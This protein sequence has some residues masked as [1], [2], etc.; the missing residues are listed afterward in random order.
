MQNSP[1]F[2]PYVVADIGG[3]NARFAL[4][5]ELGSNGTK[6]ILEN[7]QT[8]PSSEFDSL[9]QALGLFLSTLNGIKVKGACLAVAGP[10]ARDAFNLTNL[11]WEGSLSSMKQKTG[12]EN[13]L[14]LNDFAAYAYSIRYLNDE[15][16]L[17][18][19]AGSSLA[20]SPIAVLGPGT[21]FGVA[22]LIEGYKGVQTIPMEG[23]HI[24]LAA[25]NALQAEV[26]RL[27]SQKFERVTVER[28]LSGPGIQNIYWALATIEGV[29]INPLSTSEICQVA[30]TDSSDICHRTMA[31]YCAW[32]GAVAGDLAL[33]LG[34]RG[35]VFL[36][37]GV[38]PRISDFLLASDFEHAFAAKE[39]VQHYIKDIPVTLVIEGNTALTGAAAWYHDHT[40]RVEHCKK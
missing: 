13:I 9:E 24:S 19:K 21:G 3:T 17:D 16:K 8:Y 33:A 10:V 32:L 25:N 22:S 27:L 40:V 14:L 23:G 39:P 36:G 34:A 28:V 29:E 31:L 37:G 6:F 30:A 26:K 15:Q 35:G 5:N 1:N 7:R 12:L 4:V 18:V 2:I 11:G 20:G 38:L